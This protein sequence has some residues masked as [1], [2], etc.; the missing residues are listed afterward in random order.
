[1]EET[2]KDEAQDL[3]LNDKALSKK[4]AEDDRKNPLS[5]V[6]VANP[7]TLDIDLAKAADPDKAAHDAKTAGLEKTFDIDLNELVPIMAD[8]MAGDQNALNS[9]AFACLNLAN[10]KAALDWL[11]NNG[12]LADQLKALLAKDSWRLVFRAK[13]PTAEEFLGYDYIGPQSETLYAPVKKHFIE[14]FNPMK[15]YR[16]TVLCP[17]IGWGKCCANATSIKTPTG[18]TTIGEMKVGDKVCTPE[19]GVTTVTGVFP[20]GFKK[21]LYTFTF[22]DGRSVVAGAE[23]LWKAS[24]NCNSSKHE[25]GKRVYFKPQ[26]IWKTVT[27]QQIIDDYARNPRARWCIPLPKAVIHEERP[28]V[29]H[30]Y[31]LGAYLG[32]GCFT[33]ERFTL[34]GDDREIFNRV[35]ETAQGLPYTFKEKMKVKCSVNY[36]LWF[37]A[38]DYSFKSDLLRLKLFGTN[39]DT[40]FIPDEYL[41]DSVENRWELLRGL[42]DTDGFA[43]KNGRTSFGTNSERLRD[44]IC[45]LVRGLGGLASWDTHKRDPEPKNSK[46]SGGKPEWLVFIQMP[47]NSQPL[48]R[49]KRKQERVDANFNRE[50]TRRSTEYLFIKSIEKAPDG[51]ATCILVDDPEHLYLAGDYIVTHNSLFTVLSNLYISTCVSLMWHPYK[52]FGQSQPLDRDVWTPNGPKKM[53]DMRVGDEV[54]TPGGG[55]ATVVELHPQGKIP[56]YEIEL[57]DGRVT[58]CSAEHLWTVSWR[59]GV[60]GRKAWETV[61]TKFMIEHPELDFELPEA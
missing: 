17:C 23:H 5:D 61:T 27:T 49:V 35:M 14:S 16:T 6:Q 37:L 3:Y 46:R 4:L 29:I 26:R 51:E 45:T 13:P 1:M 21:D 52:Y 18:N 57:D 8:I 7:F 43:D 39:S 60:D 11:V 19:G 40:K 30:P 24:N 12:Q 41:Y 20:Q 32:D 10:I 55:T 47:D 28:H 15:P 9:P 34:V 56:T 58:R 38:G 22:K 59:R 33:S 36:Q 42:M 25:N 50:R 44:G 2:T 31:V 48:F 53:G 54:L